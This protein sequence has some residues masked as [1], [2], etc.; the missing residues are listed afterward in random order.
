MKML[1]WVL[2][3]LENDYAHICLRILEQPAMSLVIP[4]GVLKQN[5]ISVSRANTWVVYK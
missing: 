1:H 4:T 3:S 5:L 2:L